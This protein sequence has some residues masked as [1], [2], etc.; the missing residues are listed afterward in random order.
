MYR[1]LIFILLFCFSMTFT[2]VSAFQLPC[3]SKLWHQKL[4][5]LQTSF[6]EKVPSAAVLSPILA[7]AEACFL[8]KG[9]S[10]GYFKCKMLELDHLNREGRSLETINK[11]QQ[12]KLAEQIEPIATKN[13]SVAADIC[14]VWAFALQDLG[15]MEAAFLQFEKSARFFEKAKNYD[16]Y[17][18]ACLSAAELAYRNNN[19]FAVVKDYFSKA[20]QI[21]LKH[22][23][24]NSYIFS[25]LYQTA[26]AIFY[27]EG[28]FVKATEMAEKGL[29]IEL[30]KTNID[31]EKIGAWYKQLS[32]LYAEQLDY[33][34]SLIYALNSISYFQKL[35]NPYLLI[36]LY[37]NICELY[38]NLE[39]KK[40]AF[41]YFRKCQALIKKTGWHPEQE[42]AAGLYSYRAL[43]ACYIK[44]NMPDSLIAYLTPLLG[45]IE[46]HN[47]KIEDAYKYLGAAYQF[48]RD[49]KTAE[50][51]LKKTLELNKKRFG[52]NGNKLAHSYY[53]LSELY[54]RSNDWDNCLKSLDSLFNMLAVPNDGSG[55]VLD[56]EHVVSHRTLTRAF[57]QRGK[58][59]LAKE[60]YKDAHQDYELAISLLHYLKDNYS[61]DASK[62]YTVEALRPLYEAASHAA[63][64]LQKTGNKNVLS[65][66][67]QNLIFEYAENSKATLL[68][69]S[70]VKFRSH[71]RESLGIPDSILRAE[72]QML[73]QIEEHRE[74]LYSAQ[75]KNDSVAAQK[76][77]GL[78]L[79]E[80]RNIEEFDANLDKVYP[81]YKTMRESQQSIATIAQVQKV[82]EPGTVLIE[83]FISEHNAYIF[84]IS[85]EK[86]DIKII[87]DHSLQDLRAHIKDLRNILTDVHYIN[88]EREQGYQIFINKAY[89]LYDQYLKHPMLEGNKN[90]IIVPDRE[91]NY[92]PYEV[93]LTAPQDADGPADY[94]RLPYL[95]KS[96]T[97]R[98][99]YSATVMVNHEQKNEH[100]GNGRVLA[101]APLYEQE[102]DYT[103]LSTSIKE[104]RTPKEVNIHKN[105]SKLAGAQKELQMI[106]TW[107][108]G[109]FFYNNV[110]SEK[111]FKELA[112]KPYS[113][114]H[115]AMHGLV[116]FDHPSYSAL[117]FTEDL[118]S[119]EDN[120]LY[121]YEINHLDFRNIDL[122]V[123]SAC[124]TGY[125]KY[126]L[127]EGV[128]S[129]GR[130]FMHAGVSSIVSTLW[131]L[132][133]Q[134]SVEIMKSFYK[135]LSLG[136]PKDEALRDAKLEYLNTHPDMGS[137][138]FFW[139][140]IIQIGDPSPIKLHFNTGLEFLWIVLGAA[141]ISFLISIHL[142]VKKYKRKGR[143][144]RGT[145]LY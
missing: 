142:M 37:S 13:A 52:N 86:S 96:Y 91:F 71:Y 92:I 41:D 14:Y 81:K 115:L 88:K 143:A 94:A 3:D 79:E 44:L 135:N 5:S 87:E 29:Q 117:V 107:S 100:R 137:H 19:E 109:D 111:N 136:K 112:S 66:D 39:K 105:L 4:D 55:D 42:R 114:V 119:I 127:G 51:Y 128:V 83:Y 60:M 76:W 23:D 63:Y 36:D 50:I 25:Y 6:D 77:Q 123:L 8:Q 40:E 120:L 138:P 74:M 48:K 57:G 65:K 67:F 132:N 64:Q 53:F 108:D 110:A 38:Y 35:D 93:L 101:F 11:I 102:M 130:S 49:F 12:Y 15:K 54:A 34:Q 61:S 24:K 141:F 31:N 103:N 30:K 10:M 122:V 84:Y 2:E 80:Q 113:V 56:F 7:K 69:E 59:Y 46:R 26:A 21:A 58:A 82:L 47:L 104:K 70:I 126:A 133:D 22:L 90:L 17:T 95:L 121:A 145:V 124:Q 106:E 85:K 75:Q 131:E 16:G 73:N 118:D 140:G 33:N 32:I 144:M 62:H 9:D 72:E 45:D 89:Y 18:D 97:I 20:E 1:D 98:Y 43:G 27:E 116:D 139:A 99:E 134:S 68:N 78:I 125:G 129:L 28:D